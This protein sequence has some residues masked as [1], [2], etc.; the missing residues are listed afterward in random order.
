M[1][2]HEAILAAGKS[3]S[4][5]DHWCVEGMARDALGRHISPDSVRAVQ[6]C[7]VGAIYAACGCS[8]S[9]F[10]NEVAEAVAAIDLAANRLYDKSIV[11]VNDELGHAEVLE[12]LRLAYKQTKPTGA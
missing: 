5:K 1:D 8:P 12:C 6:W 11:C 3:L 4:D 7:A 10:T 2:A 9:S